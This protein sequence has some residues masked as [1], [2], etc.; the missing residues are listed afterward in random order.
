MISAGS[1]AQTGVV[2]IYELD[3][4]EIVAIVEPRMRRFLYIVSGIVG[5]VTVT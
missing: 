5:H 2:G 1:N 4:V 3:E